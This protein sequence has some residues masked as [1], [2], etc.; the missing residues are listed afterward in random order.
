[1]DGAI[2]S[3]WDYGG[4]WGWGTGSL[5]SEPLGC[6]L[7]LGNQAS[8]PAPSRCTSPGSPSV[9]CGNGG[10]AGARFPW[11]EC[12]N[13]GEERV[14]RTGPQ[15]FLLPHSPSWPFLTLPWYRI[16]CTGQTWQA[17]P[18]PKTSRTR[19]SSSA[20]RNSF[21]VILRSTTRNSPCRARQIT[22]EPGGLPCCSL[23]VDGEKETCH[24][25]QSPP[26]PPILQ[27]CNTAVPYHSGH[28]K[29]ACSHPGPGQVQ[30]T[31]SDYSR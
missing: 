9:P 15:P 22:S 8:S 31:L 12:G 4:L 3:W 10:Q 14:V 17:V 13:A 27:S 29:T 23:R 30:Q 19:P 26:P 21:M 7:L 6:E 11:W 18:E 25:A 28:P 1:M 5:S 16:W 24:C 2:F 20:R